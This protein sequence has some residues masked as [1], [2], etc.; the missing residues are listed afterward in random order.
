MVA[1]LTAC[2]LLN[3][4]GWNYSM[5]GR[6]Q[7]DQTESQ[8]PGTT[9]FTVV[10]TNGGP[11]Q[12][13]WYSNTNG[14][15]PTVPFSVVATGSAPLHYQWY[16]NTNANGGTTQLNV[17]ASSSPAPTYQWYKSTNTNEGAQH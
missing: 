6:I 17:G 13:Q 7:S 11:L 10:S 9:Q 1:A 8:T 4:C 2:G 15:Q 12:Y 3:G 16:F 5:S 14:N